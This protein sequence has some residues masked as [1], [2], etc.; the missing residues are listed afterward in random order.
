MGIGWGD[1]DG[2]GLEDLFVT[3]LDRETH[4]L[5]KQGPR[6]LYRDETVTS[7][8]SQP[9][10][11]STGFGTVLGDFDCDGALDVAI[12]NGRVS[13]GPSDDVGELSPFW[14]CYAQRHQ[15][16]ANDGKGR[17]RD[18]SLFNPA[19]CDR[20]GVGR[21]LLCGD[22]E[23]NGCM[24]LLVTEVA[25]RARLF[26]NVAPNRGN[27]LEVRACE[28]P[29]K[30]DA[31][32]AELRVRAAGRNWVRTLQASGGYLCSQDSRA[33][34]GL[35]SATSFDAVEVRWP[36]GQREVFPGGPANLHLTLIKGAGRPMP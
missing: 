18:L 35:G 6:G 7:R 24:G 23:N 36:D 33:H 9:H 2:D 29:S 32:G 20:P 34:F 4:T 17:F 31:L 28:T 25:G 19:L 5:W 16:F 14:S 13:K 21:G 15:L 1:L 10:W 30:R 27:W 11:R 8:L 3:H 26:R 22:F 12:V